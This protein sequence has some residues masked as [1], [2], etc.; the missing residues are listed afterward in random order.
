MNAH[1]TE[2]GVSEQAAQWLIE[3]ED[4]LQPAAFADFTAWLKASPRHVEEF[5]L[6]AAA[7]GQFNHID[8]ERRIDVR[9]LMSATV[10]NVVALSAEKDPPSSPRSSSR[11]WRFGAAAAAI[12]AAVS[13]S[14]WLARAHI[15][16][17]TYATAIGEQ[18][19]IKLTDGSL[20]QLNTG[21]RVETHLTGNARDVRLLEGEA[22][23]T[24]ARDISRPFRVDSG[25]IIIQ[26]VGTQFNVYR[27]EDGA[28]VSV[29]EGR[30]RVRTDSAEQALEAGEEVNIAANGRIAKRRVVDIANAAAW[31]ERRLVFRDDTLADI[32][33]EF[34]R[35]NAQYQIRLE[36]DAGRRMRLTGVFRADDPDAL[37]LYLAA[38]TDLQIDG[39]STHTGEVT[40]H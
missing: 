39:R 32:V 2:P 14:V 25:G 35:Y 21:S 38:N 9:T 20:I 33:A 10:D 36:G 17:S 22:L 5:L 37:V 12:V 6:A 3:L 13:M 40:V 34:N 19:S 1:R 16:A 27:R 4:E 7:W 30:V 28:K 15:V 26:A 11:A 31:R 23:F 29:I 8:R 18:R 24:V